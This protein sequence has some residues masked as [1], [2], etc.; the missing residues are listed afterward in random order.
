[1]S[2]DFIAPDW[3]A[4]QIAEASRVREQRRAAAIADLEHATRLDGTTMPAPRI[5]PDLHC[6]C[7]GQVGA[8]TPGDHLGIGCLDHIE[9]DWTSGQ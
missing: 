9:H 7:G 8:R 2:G 4:E 3:T 5:V 6:W 1:M